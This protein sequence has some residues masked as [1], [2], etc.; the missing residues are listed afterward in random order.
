LVIQQLL[1]P[2]VLHQHHRLMVQNFDHFPLQQFQLCL[3]LLH[4]FLLVRQHFLLMVVR[5]HHFLLQLLQH[6]FLL[7]ALE[8]PL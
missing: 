7:I 1:L 6:L 4:Y 5:F 2:L 8:L 3:L